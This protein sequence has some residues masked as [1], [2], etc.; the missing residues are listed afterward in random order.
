MCSKKI[1]S[2]L[3]I[4]LLT[5]CTATKKPLS[6][7]AQDGNTP[8]PVIA[9][10]AELNGLHTWKINGVIAA[11][12]ASKGFTA[13][14]DWQQ[15]SLNHYRIQLYGPFGSNDVIIVK[16]GGVVTYREGQKIIQAPHA[17]AILQKEMGVRMPVNHLYYWVRGIP[18]P[19]TVQ[20]ALRDE[21]NHLVTLKQDGFTIQYTNYRLIDGFYLPHNIH[22]HGKDI[23]IKLIIKQWRL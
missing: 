5:A 9:E 8:T 19:S 11:K 1:Y 18:S 3:S 13:S 17:D 7:Q 10:K 15:L 14:I 16:N 6:T 4:A 21:H 2:L 23:D 12:S 22:M 20:E